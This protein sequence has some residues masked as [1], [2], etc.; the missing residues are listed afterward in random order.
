MARM[1]SLVLC[2][3]VT[4]WGGPAFSESAPNAT[5]LGPRPWLD[6]R[7]VARPTLLVAEE[8]AAPQSGADAL[9]NPEV[10]SD[11]EARIAELQAKRD[12]IDTR[13]PRFW[14]ITGGAMTGVGVVIA[15]V[16]LVGCLGSSEAGAGCSPEHW[17][18]LGAS[19]GLLTVGGIA[20]LV[21]NEKKLRE[22][23]RERRTLEQEIG[24]LRAEKD[25]AASRSGLRIG[26][27]PNSKALTLGW[28]Y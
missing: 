6:D 2:F 1:L 11:V 13:R 12:A 20:T 28:V 27:D 4:T 3:A 24:E 21:P 15:V 18:G 19:A 10:S 25:E 26:F 9:E 22:R 23:T 14:T 17:A 8:D 16:T 5:T 7:S